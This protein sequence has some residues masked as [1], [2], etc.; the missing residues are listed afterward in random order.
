MNYAAALAEFLG[1]FI[2]LASVLLTGNWLVIGAT[3]GGLTLATQNISGGLMNPAVSFALWM[4]GKIESR[5]FI[6]YSIAQVAGALAAAL[7]LK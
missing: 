6:G 5:E 7:L 3:L 1:T 4:K 2:L